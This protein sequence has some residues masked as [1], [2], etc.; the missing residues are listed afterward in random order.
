VNISAYDNLGNVAYDNQTFYVDLSPPNVTKEVGIPNV[1]AGGGDYYITNETMIWL[2]VTEDRLCDVGGW[3]IH[4]RILNDTGTYKQGTN[5][6][7]VSVKIN[8]EC[9]HTLGYWVNDSL[10]N[11]Y[12][13]GGWHNEI[14]YVDASPPM[15]SKEYGDFWCEGSA[16]CFN[17]T[18]DYV[19]VQNHSSLIPNNSNWTVEAWINTTTTTLGGIVRKTNV[20]SWFATYDLEIKADGNISW[21]L[22][23]DVGN[24]ANADSTAPVNDGSWHHILGVKN[25]STLELYIDGVLHN[26]ADGSGL[27]SINPIDDLYIGAMSNGG[28]P[29]NFFDGCID[30]VR[31]Y[32]RALMAGEVMANYH[33]DITAT[34]LV[35]WWKFDERVGT[36]AHDYYRFNNG[37]IVGA[38]WITYDYRHYISP[39][40]NIYINATGE[41]D[42]SSNFTIYYRFKRWN[43]SWGGWQQGTVNEN[44]VFTIPD[45]CEHY[46]EFYAVD[47]LGHNESGI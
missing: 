18:T 38:T 47:A 9:T 19:H 16:L 24:S 45:E 32:N 30:D 8:E 21:F 40:T 41:Q 33:G 10:G 39:A 37:T 2:N 5:S 6:T 29:L 20:S 23:D 27:G 17:G 46:I 43:E 25:G 31:I 13:P 44:V 42:C 22:R 15:S 34:G 1:P 35:S 4:W 7:N 14:F 12:P 11:R 36:V 26:T 3:T 28:A